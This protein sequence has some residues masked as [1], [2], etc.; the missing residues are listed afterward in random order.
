MPLLII[1]KSLLAAQTKPGDARA[2]LIQGGA[3]SP[4]A[5][6]KAPAT[7]RMQPAA[8]N[9]QYQRMI[10]NPNVRGSEI[11]TSTASTTAVIM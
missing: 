1:T 10:E 11:A 8:A 9:N 5:I 7:A 2:T 3:P 4:L 6:L